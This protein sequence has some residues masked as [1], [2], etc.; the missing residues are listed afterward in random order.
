LITAACAATVDDLAP[1][2]LYIGIG[3]G[4]TGVWHLGLSTAKLA[5][6]EAYV[7]AVR[8]LLETGGAEWHGHALTLPWAAPP[9]PESWAPARR[10]RSALPGESPTAS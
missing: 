2:R 1:G 3:A 5:E 8:S 10:A 7:L 6:L 9:H 4:G